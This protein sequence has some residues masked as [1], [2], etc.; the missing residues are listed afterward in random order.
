MGVQPHPHKHLH[1]LYDCSAVP[2]QDKKV[3]LGL[4]AASFCCASA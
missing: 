3:E 2:G 4:R 1:L